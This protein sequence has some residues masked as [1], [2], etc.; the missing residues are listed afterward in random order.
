[1]NVTFCQKSAR[2]GLHVWKQAHVCDFSISTRF[3]NSVV[4]QPGG[5][6]LRFIVVHMHE[7]KNM[8]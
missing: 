8:E 1:M 4:S 6:V 5:G 3:Q 7:Q 2:D